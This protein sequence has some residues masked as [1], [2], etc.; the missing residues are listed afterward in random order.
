MERWFVNAGF[1]RMRW[2]SEVGT[3]LIRSRRESDRNTASRLSVVGIAVGVMALVTVLS[4]MNGFQLGTIEAMLEVNSYH[5]R[6]SGDVAEQ[7]DSGDIG[8]IREV[9]GVRA[10]V[11]FSETETIA[12]GFFETTRGTVVRSVPPDVLERDPG[13]ADNLSL[14][15]GR[16]DFAESGTIMLGAELRRQLG[17][18]IGDTVSFVTL[19]PR[20]GGE[21]RASRVPREAHLTVSGSFRTGFFEYDAGWAYVSEETAAETFGSGAGEQVVGI[22]LDDRFAEGRMRQRVAEA[23]A[24]DA[25]DVSSWREY[26][27]AIFGALRT[28]KVTMSVLLGLIFVVVAANIY[29]SLRRSVHD[30][31]EEISILKALGAKPVDIQLVFVFEGL[32]IGFVGALSGLALG[33]FV[34]TNVNALFAGAELM[35]NSVLELLA[36]LIGPIAGGD[37]VQL[38]SPQVF[39]MTEVPVAIVFGEVVAIVAFAIAA[40]A[41]AAWLASMRAAGVRP[42]EVLRNE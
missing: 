39:Y 5:L 18:R 41:A 9:D 8:D 2:I 15:D 42:A 16:L 20:T 1:K 6:I 29:Q 36:A 25:D 28:E 32:V 21:D 13:L 23:L 24:I 10:V 11:P 38:F 30:R 3:R 7:L 35:V 22:K 33:L 4:V 14:V 26:N 12:R 17:V 40:A 19:G 37:A 34:S 27:R 31:A